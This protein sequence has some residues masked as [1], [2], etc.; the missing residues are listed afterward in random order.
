MT[1]V[2]RV[3]CFASIQTYIFGVDV[4]PLDYMAEVERNAMLTVKEEMKTRTS[5]CPLLY[6]K[7]VAT[8][9][10]NLR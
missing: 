4:L 7:S 3:V 10:T 9:F 8:Y 5:A 2:A 1:R 6:S